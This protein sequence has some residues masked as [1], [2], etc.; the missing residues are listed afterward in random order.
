MTVLTYS[1]S[2]YGKYIVN[3]T[4][5]ESRAV[6]DINALKYP[7]NYNILSSNY[8][9]SI[10]D[11]CEIYT[12]TNRTSVSYR[13]TYPE[14]NLANDDTII[15][16]HR[17][18]MSM[19]VNNNIYNFICS[20]NHSFITSIPE[21]YKINKYKFNIDVDDNSA[22]PVVLLYDDKNIYQFYNDSLKIIRLDKILAAFSCGS[23]MISY[24]IYENGG[25]KYYLIRTYENTYIISNIY[26][27]DDN[28]ENIYDI[29]YGKLY[30]SNRY[31]YLHVIFK[32]NIYIL[33]CS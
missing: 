17:L 24:I 27:L 1:V 31:D 20:R 14:I 13:Y 4:D 9:F 7:S 33:Y 22:I 23:T 5:F 10:T 3:I 28:S 29:Q 32:T 21:E 25:L 2:S 11:K 19:N 15:F 12:H 16:H 30:E 18:S 6:V 8:I 26:D